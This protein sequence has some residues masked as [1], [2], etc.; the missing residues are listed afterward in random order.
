MASTPQVSISTSL[1]C[2]NADK[3]TGF[4]TWTRLAFSFSAAGFVGC[5]LLMVTFAVL[6]PEK[7]RR[8]YLQV[9]LTLS[10]MLEAVGVHN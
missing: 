6:P 3:N 8:H 9:C 1:Q 10:V 2:S 5:F 7:T 4:K